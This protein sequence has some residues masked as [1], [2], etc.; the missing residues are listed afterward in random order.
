MDLDLK[1]ERVTAKDKFEVGAGW[2]Y[3]LIFG[4]AAIIVGWGLDAWQLAASSAELFWAKV[5]LAS[6]TILP[7]SVLAGYLAS[8][9]RNPL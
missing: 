4:L 6:L 8:R 1:T 9:F 7:L 3:G 5:L 2:R